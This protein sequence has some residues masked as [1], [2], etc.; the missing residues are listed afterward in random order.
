M[1]VKVSESIFESVKKLVNAEGDNYFD[2]DLIIHINTVF[3]ILTQMGVGP[4]E[5]FSIEDKSSTWDEFTDDVELY[6]MVKSY[7][8]LRVKLLFD[9]STATSYVI[10]TWKEQADELEWRLRAAA[11]LDSLAD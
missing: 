7:M 1:A 3:S 2:T 5:G 6:N 9:I 11:E 4:T 8:V 10:S